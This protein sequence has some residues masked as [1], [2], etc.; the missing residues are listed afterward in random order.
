[1]MRQCYAV[2][3]RDKRPTSALRR[4]LSA[5]GAPEGAGAGTA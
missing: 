4:F 3:H 5:A 2:M 1:M